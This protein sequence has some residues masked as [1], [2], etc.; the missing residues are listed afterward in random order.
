MFL[1]ILIYFLLNRKRKKRTYELF[2]QLAFKK[3]CHWQW[4]VLDK[5]MCYQTP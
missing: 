2:K 5:I 1:P 3:W 4:K